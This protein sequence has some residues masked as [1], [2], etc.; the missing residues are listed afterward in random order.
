MTVTL[1][2]NE[3]IFESG[4]QTLVCPV[5]CV[6]VMGKGLALKFARRWSA[7]FKEYLMLCSWDQLIWGKCKLYRPDAPD[8]PA[9]ILFPTKGHWKNPSDIQRLKEGLR[10]LE[11]NYSGWHLGSLAVPA[12]GCGEGGL[13]WELV[14]PLLMEHFETYDIPV[15]IYAPKEAHDA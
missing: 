15:E 8:E 1:I 11:I 13:N 7:L 6:G 14:R 2:E 4:A 9:V 5:N 10:H 3:D 12:L